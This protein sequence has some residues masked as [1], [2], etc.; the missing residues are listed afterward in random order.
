MELVIEGVEPS[1]VARVLASG[2]DHGGN[3]VEPFVDDEGGWQLRCCLADSQVGDR[4]TVI[5]YSP[6]P[7]NGPFR[8]TGPIVVH[9]EGCP[10]TWQ[11]SAIPHQFD[12]RAM[13]LRPYGPDHKIAYDHVRHVS[14]TDGIA[15]A[16]V[17]LLQHSE[18]SEVYARNPLAGCFAFTAR[19]AS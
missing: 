2:V 16:L 7:W 17:E 12:D 5:A 6:F 4:I 1:E 14:S 18:V 3:S 15:D 9:A 19:R 8:E 11:Q 10:G 13:V